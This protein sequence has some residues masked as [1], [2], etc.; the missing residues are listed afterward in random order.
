VEGKDVRH[1]SKGVEAVWEV[2]AHHF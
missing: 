2:R 1:D